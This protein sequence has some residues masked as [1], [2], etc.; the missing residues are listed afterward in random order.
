M[1]YNAH[2]YDTGLLSVDGSNVPLQSVDVN[3]VLNNLICET[4]VRQTYRNVEDKNI[5]A[6]YTFPVPLHAVLISLEVTIGD[7][8]LKG[9]VVEKSNAVNQYEDAITEGDTAIML[10]QT[11]PGMY[12]MNIGNLMPGEETI[13]SVT[14]A[15]L[16]HWQGNSLRFFL[17][18]TIAPRYGNPESAGLNLIKPRSIAL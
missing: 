6:V 4:T 12:A 5:E 3:S 14:C 17:P 7:R 11:E 9:I 15:E 2:A 10:E 1:N 18:T 16:H 8:V 13:I